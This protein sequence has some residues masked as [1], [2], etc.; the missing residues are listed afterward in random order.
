MKDGQPKAIDATRPEMVNSVS[1]YAGFVAGHYI[2]IGA[3]HAAEAGEK[4]IA[5]GKAQGIE[6]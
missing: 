6:A 3:A 5:M 4:L 2:E 1:R